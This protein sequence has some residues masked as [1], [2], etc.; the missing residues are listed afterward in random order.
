MTMA[1]HL[2][3][4]VLLASLPLVVVVVLLCEPLAVS[5]CAGA[6]RD[7]RRRSAGP[8]R[9]RKAQRGSDRLSD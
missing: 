2:R 5:R 1:H 7:S 6:D 4:A 8:A 9:I 3:L